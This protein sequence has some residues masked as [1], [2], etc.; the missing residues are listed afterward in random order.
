MKLQHQKEEE[1][2]EQRQ[3]NLVAGR[4]NT[5]KRRAKKS[6]LCSCRKWNC[7][8]FRVKGKKHCDTRGVTSS[9][10]RSQDAENTC[11]WRCTNTRKGC[12]MALET[13]EDRQCVGISDGEHNHVAEASDIEKER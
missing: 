7:G 13:N 9:A 6:K 10:S 4:P 11:H 12:K 3:Q 2:I 1:N 5:Q 8:L